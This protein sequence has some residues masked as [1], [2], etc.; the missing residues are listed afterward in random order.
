MIHRR[1]PGTTLVE[2]LVILGVL[3]ALLAVILPSIAR[4]AAAGRMTGSS[5]NLR[6]MAAAHHV[7]AAVWNGRQVTFV[8]DLIATYGRHL[9][10]FLNYERERGEW[11]PPVVLGWGLS[12]RE[13]DRRWFAYRMTGNCANTM[14]AVPIAFTG[15]NKALREFGSF[16]LTNAGQFNRYVN[17]RFY[18]ETFYTPDDPV[19]FEAVDDGGCFDDPDEYCNFAE[20]CGSID[21]PAWSSYCLSPAAMF[22]PR[23]MAHDDPE[24]PLYNGW[25]DPWNLPDGFRSPPVFHAL[26]PHLKT[27][28]LE[29]HWI[30]GEPAPPR[31]NPAFDP[32]TYGKDCCEPYYFNHAVTSAPLT[33]F[34]D[35]HVAPIVVADAMADD[36]RVREQNGHPNWGLWS[37]DTIFG[38]DGYFIP[39]GYDQAD[40]SFHVLTT[41]GILGRDILEPGGLRLRARSVPRSDAKGRPPRRPPFGST[42]GVEISP[43][44]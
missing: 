33:L 2:T 15:C 4:G 43:R 28:V 44:E 37:K 23:V 1:R 6:T 5:D 32:G 10:A 41:D 36:E 17:G 21:V 8:D 22:N 16:R 18:D 7:Y 20:R 19:V 3:V 12:E 38:D 30:R 42:P 40:T 11:H 26:Y 27:H 25:V 31:C 34:Y 13:N 29:R 35:G 9:T 24:H 14:L 39:Y